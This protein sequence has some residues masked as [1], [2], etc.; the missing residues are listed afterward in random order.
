MDLDDRMALVTPEGVVVEY[1][2]AD[3]GSRL[4]ATFIDVLIQA[5][6]VIVLLIPISLGNI[7]M[8]FS[9]IG[10]F[11]VLFGYP[12]VFDLWGDGRSP[13]KRVLGLQVR[14]SN[15]SGVGFM[16]SLIRNLLRLIDGPLTLGLVGIISVAAT[17]KHQRLG[18]L[19][20]STVVIRLKKKMHVP[21]Q[22]PGFG[23][24]NQGYQVMPQALTLIDVSALSPSD[25]ASIQAFLARR[26]TL[27]PMVRYQIGMQFAT[28]IV[29]RVA[30]LPHGLPPETALE[31]IVAAKTLR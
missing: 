4:A 16:A 10:V 23:Q 6:I 9:V 2:L 26:W 19:A 14:M 24:A 22:L 28:A 7:G 20:A 29:P 21:P 27:E 30:G 25:I 12:T 8:A 13:G 3:A 18:D 15:G 31:W 17:P 11:I 1:S 5:V